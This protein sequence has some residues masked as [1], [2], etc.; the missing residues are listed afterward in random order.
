M[1]RAVGSGVRMIET[2]VR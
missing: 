2:D 1:E